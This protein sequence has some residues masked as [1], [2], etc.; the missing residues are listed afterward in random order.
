VANDIITADDGTTEEQEINLDD[1]NFDNV[2][3]E[4]T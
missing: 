4:S 2:A 3:S 1:T